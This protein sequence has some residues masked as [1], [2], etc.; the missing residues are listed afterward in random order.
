MKIILRLLTIIIIVSGHTVFSQTLHQYYQDGIVVFQ[1]KNSAKVI[2]SSEKYVDHNKVDLFSQ[3]LKHFEIVDVKRLHPTINDP[4]LV[5]TYQINLSNIKDVDAVINTLEKHPDIAYAELKELPE[6]TLTPNDPL[7]NQQWYLNRIDAELAW[8][9]STGNSNVVVAVTDNAINVDH[10]DLTNKMVAG[11]DAVDQDNDPRGCGS[12]TGFHGSHVS[13]IVGAETNNNLGVSSIGNLVSIMPVKIGNCNGSLVAAYDG[14]IWAADN[15]ADIINMSWGGG[16]QSNYG[17]NVCTYAWNQGS[18]LIAAAGNNNQSNEFFPAAYDNVVSVASSNGSDQKSGFSQYGSWIDITA[19]G[20]AILSTD[21]Q[22]GYA[23][24][25]GTSMAS[26]LVAG[27]VGLMK[28]YAFNATNT[29]I[30]NCLLSSADNIDSQNPSYIG[31]LGSGRINALAA[32]TC[33]GAYLYPDDASITAIINPIESV[34]G[35]TFI[36]EVELTNM[37]AD[38]LTSAEITFNWNGI[39]QTISWSGNL[40]STQSEIIQLPVQ[41]SQ[42]GTFTFEVFSSLPNG[43]TDMNTSNDQATR[44][45]TIQPYG[46]LVDLQ[47]EMDCFGSEITWEIIDNSSGTP[48]VVRDGGGYADITGG[49]FISEEI[50]LSPGCYTFAIYDEFG[51]GLN[52][53]SANSCSVDGDYRLVNAN[54]TVLFE[55]TAQNGAFGNSAQHEFCVIDSN[56]PNDAGIASIVY[57]SGIVC[58]PTFQ[59]QVLLKN[60]GNDPLTSVTI[61]YQTVGGL[62]SFAWTGNLAFNQTE[63]VTLPQTVTGSGTVTIIA[64]TSNPNNMSDS[65][66]LNDGNQATYEET[67]NAVSL[68]FI[69]DFET[70]VFA[71]GEW[72]IEN[73]DNDIT[74]ELATVDGITP[75]TQAAKMDLFSYNNSD[76]RDAII[77]PKISLIGY[78]SAEMTFDHAYRRLNPSTNDTLIIYVSSDCG[79]TW[80]REFVEAENGS[81]SL[82][83]ASTSVN[84]FT[85]SVPQ[86]WCFGGGAGSDCFVI[87]LNAYLGQ[88]I[89]V[90]FETYKAED[91]GNNIY[92]DNINITGEIDPNFIVANFGIDNYSICAGETA[93]FSDLSTG[94]IDAWNWSFEGGSPE[95]SSA[96]NPSVRYDVPGIYDVNLEISNAQSVS[97]KSTSIIVLAA[98]SLPNI[99]QLGN[100]LSVSLESGETAEWSFGGETVGFGPTIA[101]GED[102]TYTVTVSS[103]NGCE[104]SGSKIFSSSVALED[105]YSIFP[106]PTN[107]ILNI[108]FGGYSDP[109]NIGVFDALGRKIIDTDNF[110]TSQI[111]QLDLSKFAAGTYSVVFMSNDE[112]ITAKIVVY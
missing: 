93:N 52:G 86:D 1:L 10:P 62:Q 98:P 94:S 73:P 26:P 37:G 74:W 95:S 71:S 28:S 38:P 72:R 75:G 99:I 42:N 46:Q 8:D 105:A 108:A 33:V 82:A 111:T 27:L 81:G 53:S 55:M 30:I 79:Q 49:E 84:L 6:T 22:S 103:A 58:E 87:D 13:G 88:D 5:R 89:L 21:A 78:A 90:K 96:Q 69:E 110:D 66:P 56:N 4:A 91:D 20:S 65:A 64:S 31:Q 2:P 3:Y 61:N 24:T 85:P 70:D 102:G 43:V 92:I 16:G 41:N 57:P 19:P 25:Q 39:P 44:T 67:I 107:G 100:N 23:T 14:I 17:Q 112:R 15:D 35:T 63:V 68:P 60:Y 54:G 51:D 29:Q 48:V 36:P 34:C 59:P 12:N 9:I 7:L 80:N 11:Y 106:N 77:S 76:Q 18:I 45:F 32:M 109:I 104:N 40:A 47:L 97:T 101:M 83:T 50:C